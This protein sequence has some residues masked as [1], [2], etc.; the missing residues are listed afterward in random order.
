MK[1]IRFY[2]EGK[3]DDE[4]QMFLSEEGIFYWGTRKEL[5]EDYRQRH[6]DRHL[7]VY[8]YSQDEYER[9][10]EN[11]LKKSSCTKDRHDF[12]GWFKTNIVNNPDFTRQSYEGFLKDN[13]SVR[14]ELGFDFTKDNGIER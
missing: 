5:V 12:G 1:D 14:R 3:G 6:P 7:M 8:L 2:G 11:E 4:R 9:N 10:R 13:N